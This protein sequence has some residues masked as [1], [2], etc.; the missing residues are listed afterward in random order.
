M[1]L[2]SAR[3]YSEALPWNVE[4]QEKRAFY[5][6]KISLVLVFDH[7]SDISRFLVQPVISVSAYFLIYNIRN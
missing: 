5:Q 7:E 3:P 4:W 6:T 1:F 2:G